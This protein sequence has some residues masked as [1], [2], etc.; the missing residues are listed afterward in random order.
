MFF[1][2]IKRSKYLILIG[3]KFIVSNDFQKNN[4]IKF[5]SVNKMPKRDLVPFLVA[6]QFSKKSDHQLALVWGPND[7]YLGPTF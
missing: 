3:K 6:L 4:C 7:F 1:N 5:L 2:R